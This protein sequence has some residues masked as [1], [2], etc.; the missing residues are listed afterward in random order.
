M[1][2]VPTSPRSRLAAA[3]LCGTLGVFG[4][5]RFY[6]GRV[7]TG[8]LMLGTLGGLGVWY[9]I[10]LVLVLVGDF[11]DGQGRRVTRWLPADQEEE[12]GDLAPGLEASTERLRER[13]T[14]VERTLDRLQEGVLELDEKLE[15]EEA[16]NA[17][18]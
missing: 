1:S 18:N 3:I 12:D 14:G 11:R 16:G 17:Q 6:V 5:H 7:A 4:V 15:R 13:M 10:D 2:A 8:L 9:V